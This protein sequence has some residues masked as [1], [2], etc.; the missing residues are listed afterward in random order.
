LFV[1]S[2]FLNSRNIFENTFSKIKYSCKNY[3]EKLVYNIYRIKQILKFAIE[4]AKIIIII[5]QKLK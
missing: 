4:I 3:R 2:S 5:K 1:V